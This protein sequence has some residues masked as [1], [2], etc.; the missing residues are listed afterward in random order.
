MTRKDSALTISER[1]CKDNQ[2]LLDEME[3]R[4][5]I[6][7]WNIDRKKLYTLLSNKK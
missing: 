5:I 3:V 6:R 2:Y 1:I 7:L 4:E